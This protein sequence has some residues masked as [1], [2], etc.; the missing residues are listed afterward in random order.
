MQTKQVLMW[1]YLLTPLFLLID[2]LFG[3]DFRISFLDQHPGWKLAYYLFCFCIG[4]LM[5]RWQQWEAILGM[6]EGG[7]N[8]L[9]LTLSILLPYYQA[10]D[11]LSSGVQLTNPLN[12]S[13]IAN[14]LLTAIFLLLS[15]NLKTHNRS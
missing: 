9:L 4:F 14:Y 2:K 15:M 12:S 3:W 13:S 5:W 11:A 6:I 1:F 8:I 7:I 10:I